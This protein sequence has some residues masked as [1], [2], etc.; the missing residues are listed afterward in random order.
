MSPAG[1][2]P[3]LVDGDITVWD[4]LAII[5]YLAEKFPQKK[6]W[7]DD[8]AAQNYVRV[9]MHGALIQLTSEIE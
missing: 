8:R 1:K 4:S 5:E 2:V 7:P 9:N 3:V 6:L